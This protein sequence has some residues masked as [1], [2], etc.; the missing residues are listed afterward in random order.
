M[1]A[2]TFNAWIGQDKHHT[3]GD[4]DSLLANV[5]RLIEAT[6]QPEVVCLQEVW[7]WDERVKGYQRVQ[8]P[9]DRFRHREARSTQLLVR[10]KGLQ[11]LGRGAREAG[12]TWWTGPKHGIQ[13]PPRVFPRAAFLEED[14]GV[15]WDTIGIHRTRLAW[16]PGGK[17]YKAEHNTLVDW[18][19][20]RPRG[21]IVYLGDHNGRDAAEELA[22]AVGGVARLRGV[23]GFV[24]VDAAVAGVHREAGSFGG[25]GHR[26]VVGRFI[27]RP[28]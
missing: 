13:H 28:Q 12:G 15:A 5:M 11:L 23:N 16:S 7:G 20:D 22:E 21:P 8:A 6:E 9:R 14:T 2:V 1:R 3:P 18:G 25:D 27:A 26:P 4:R 17:A 19:H 24:V 10:R